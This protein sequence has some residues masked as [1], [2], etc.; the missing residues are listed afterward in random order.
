MRK[1][2]GVLIA[3][4]L[5]VLMIVAYPVS[6][7]IL[8][9]NG[10]F[11]GSGS[12]MSNHHKYESYGGGS[13]FQSDSLVYDDFIVPAGG[14]T[15]TSV[16]SNNFFTDEVS[17]SS[18]TFEIRSGVSAGDGG[19]VVASGSANPQM[20]TTGRISSNGLVEYEVRISGLNINL[21]PGTYW[22]SVCPTIQSGDVY[23]YNSAT[24]GSHSFGQPQGNNG[25]S[26]WYV[27]EHYG[28]GGEY[29]RNFED[30]SAYLDETTDYS[31]G[32]E[33]EGGNPVP[34]PGAVWLL[35]SGLLG[36]VAVR[37]KRDRR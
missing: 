20:S 7:S 37:R 29:T 19:T 26:Y 8:W 17:V 28:Y 5:V 12:S 15:I 36:L 25:N 11:N 2:H 24:S 9:Y 21:T 27:F 16:W 4:L 6:A 31:M 10:D 33:G 30:V 34:I 14:W 22:L 1:V 18:A 35:G 32:V 3:F 23:S 13:Y